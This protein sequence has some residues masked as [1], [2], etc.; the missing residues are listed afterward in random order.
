MELNRDELVSQLRAAGHGDRADRAERELP[1]R[2]DKD[3]HKGLLDKIG[4]DD[5]IL[6]KLPGGLG[7]K[8]LNDIL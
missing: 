2:V 6:D 3:E 8:K 7:D 5:S 4:V 1:E